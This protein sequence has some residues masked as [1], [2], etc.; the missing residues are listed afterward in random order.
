MQ[1][2]SQSTSAGSPHLGEFA[3]VALVAPSLKVLYLPTPKAACTTIKTMLATAAGTHRPDM[4]DRLAIMHVSRAQTIHHPAVHGLTRFADLPEREQREILSSREW[5][6]IASVRDPVSRAYSAW[7]NR[8]FMRAHRRTTRVIGL[9]RDVMTAPDS[10][11]AARIDIAASFA[12]FARMLG[13]HADA[14]MVDHHFWPQSRVVR[15]DAVDYDMIVRVDQPGQID[16]V[17]TLLRDRS[18]RDVV[19][20]RLNEG[21]GVRVERVCDQKTANRL[22]TTYHADYDAFGFSRRD[23]PASVAPLVL[24]DTE[25]RLLSAYRNAF[26]RG[27]SVAQ[28]SQRR[29]GA[30]YG[31]GQM[32]RALSGLLRGNRTTGAKD[33]QP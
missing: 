2:G 29:R 25:S 26:E 23:W 16:T 9:A 21:L 12:H 17:A 15:A 13:E 18:G 32:R 30:R 1:S 11:G 33:V 3:S 8:I 28:E 22:M 24:T 27:I 7:E 6:R 31:V 14:F 20:A 19:A 5:T 4:A 10:S